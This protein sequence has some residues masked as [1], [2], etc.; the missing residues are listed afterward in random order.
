[1]DA[2]SISTQGRRIQSRNHIIT[3]SKIFSIA[4]PITHASFHNDISSRLALASDIMK[5][6]SVCMDHN[7]DQIVVLVS[8]DLRKELRNDFKYRMEG[9]NTLEIR[10]TKQHSLPEALRW[11]NDQG[12][13]LVNERCIVDRDE[14]PTTQ[15][16]EEASAPPPSHRTD[17]LATIGKS[18]K[19][20]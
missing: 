6:Y 13:V 14:S 12:S 8:Y 10:T 3:Y 17:D 7:T 18:P 20:I 19:D 11:M 2:F 5:I 1:M 4:D 16:Q 15:T 9:Y